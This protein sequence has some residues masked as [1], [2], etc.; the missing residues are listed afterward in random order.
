MSQL[1]EIISVFVAVSL[2]FIPTLWFTDRMTYNE[3]FKPVTM[4][5]KLLPYITVMTIGH[6]I[7]LTNS[8]LQSLSVT[9]TILTFVMSTAIS[10]KIV[11]RWITY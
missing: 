11:D 5:V 3:D 4:Y 6:Y 1:T 2:P 8:T 9:L 10:C 7:G